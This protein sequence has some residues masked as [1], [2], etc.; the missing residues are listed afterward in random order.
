MSADNKYVFLSDKSQLVKLFEFDE[1]GYYHREE[2]GYY[3]KY[4]DYRNDNLCHSDCTYNIFIT[5]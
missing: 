4:G 1:D 3:I 2:T 5:S